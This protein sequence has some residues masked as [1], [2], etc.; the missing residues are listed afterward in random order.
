MSRTH[1][2]PVRAVVA[3]VVA[4]SSA[5]FG[6]QLAFS[7]ADG[8]GALATGGR[9]GVVYH[10]TRLDGE[11]NGNRTVT[12]TLAYGLSDANFKN[13]DGTVIP[14]TIVFDVGGSIFLGRKGDSLGWDTQSPLSAG[15]NVTIAGQTAPGGIH[16]VGAGLK[17]NGNNAIIRH[18]TIAPG[19]GSRTLNPLGSGYYDRYVFDGMNV[20]AANVVVDHV[21]TPFAT[22]EGI[23]ADEFANNVTVQYST[24]ANGQNY[25]QQDAEGTGVVFKGH[26]LGSL[27][28]PSSSAKTSLLHNLYANEGGRTP[29]F[30]T[31]AGKLTTAGVGAV[32]DFRNNVV[33]NWLGTGGGG[34]SGQPFSANFV[35][36]YYLAG[37][38]GEVPGTATLGSDGKYT[39]GITTQTGGTGIFAGNDTTN[40]RVYQSGNVKDVNKNNAAEF[41]TN[42]TNSDFASS[43]LTATAAFGVPVYGMTESAQLAYSRVVA[44]VGANWQN[45]GVIDSGIVNGVKTGTGQ[46]IALADPTHGTDW[47]YLLSMRMDAGGNAPFNRPAAF[48]T[49]RDGMPDVWETAHG[50]DPTVASNNGDYDNNGFTNLEEYLNELGTIPAPAP[51]VFSNGE[52]NARFARIGNWTTG[53]TAGAAVGA[54]LPSRFD[55]VQINSGSANVDSVGQHAGTVRIATAT[56]QIASMNVS[57][58]WIDVAQALAV[59][60][61][62]NGSVAQSG[63]VVKATAVI[64]GGTAN[65][66][67]GFYNLSGG[68]LATGL[69]TRNNTGS[70]FIMS[71]GTLHAD[72]VTFGFANNGGTIAPGGDVAVQLIAAGGLADLSGVAP[73]AAANVGTMTVNGDLILINGTLAIDLASATAFDRLAVDGNLS[74]GGNL[75]VT[76]LDGYAAPAG[77][78]WRIATA[79]GF[80]GNFAALPAEFAI[81]RSNG[82]LF[83]TA[84]TAVP[85]PSAV[86][87]AA[88]AVIGLRRRVRP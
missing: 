84:L 64:L 73:T 22:D 63:G 77:T 13:A 47:N 20:H 30:G 49:D 29:R 67:V 66:G 62:G 46:I 1:S 44:Y 16:I 82:E 85:E 27:W 43:N 45:R 71:G 83:L 5:A 21:S 75:T 76:L 68:T 9:G 7:G 2:R 28:Q 80:T 19:Y 12:G 40:S 81:R 78:E 50:L 52:A 23:S 65:S 33:Y 36:N 57:G 34:A 38:G 51:L 31:E 61:T 56:G 24:I 42:I 74:L 11:I 35:G 53:T 39:V 15:S 69:L 3:A 55:E 18:L 41:T 87:L 72:R 25:P 32:N 70:T 48:D 6:Q 88:A 79:G 86:V 37:P 14:R 60:G 58:G 26:A 59:G 8:A 17:V 10:V 54:W 4:A